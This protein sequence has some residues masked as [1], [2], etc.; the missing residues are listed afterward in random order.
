MLIHGRGELM[1]ADI[2]ILI[3]LLVCRLLL[4]LELAHDVTDEIDHV[5]DRTFRGKVYL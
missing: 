4:S 2:D 3:V 5:F 1:F